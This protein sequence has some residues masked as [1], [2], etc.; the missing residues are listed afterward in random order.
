MEDRR[1]LVG[2]MDAKKIL[3]S[4]ELLHWYLKAGLVVSKVYQVFEFV[5]ACPFKNFEKMVADTRR[6]HSNTA[7]GDTVKVGT[8]L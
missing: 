1:L 8:K 7:F 6:E 2:V 5:P 4:S 3:L